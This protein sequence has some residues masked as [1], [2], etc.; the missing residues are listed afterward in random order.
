MLFSSTQLRDKTLRSNPVLSV[1]T[2]IP[3]TIIDLISFL[4]LSSSDLEVGHTDTSEDSSV[5]T[6]CVYREGV[7][8]KAFKRK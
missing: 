1:E 7:V 6:F 8:R 5:V 4:C 2:L 3:L